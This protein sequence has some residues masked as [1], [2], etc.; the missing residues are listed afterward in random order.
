MEKNFFDY[1]LTTG[2]EVIKCPTLILIGDL[3]NVPFLSA[4]T[5]S[6]SIDNSRL[7]VIKN[8]CHYPFFETPKEF[9][10]IVFD[11]FSPEYQN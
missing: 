11:F 7:E 3:D 2:A 8:A 10:A 9:N 4:Q 6:E 5:L 1:D